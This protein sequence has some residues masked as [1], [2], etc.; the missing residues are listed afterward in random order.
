MHT[1]NYHMVASFHRFASQSNYVQSSAIN[2]LLS[3]ELT[4][5]L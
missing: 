1:Q 2:K 4:F 3:F 5:F